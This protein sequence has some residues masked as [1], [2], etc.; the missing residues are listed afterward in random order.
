MDRLGSADVLLFEGFRFDL[1]GSDLLRLDEAGIAVPVV[2]GSRALSLLRLLVERPGKLISR[3]EIMQAVWPR[4]TVEEGNLTV[5][6]SALRRILDQDREQGSCIQT[7]AGRG[8]RFVAPVTPVGRPASPASAALSGNGSNG[9][10]SEKKQ[11]QGPGEPGQIDRTG[12]AAAARA[13]YWLWGGIMTTGIAALVL[14]AAGAVGIWR[15]PWSGDAHTA[16]R[17]SIVVLPFANLGNDPDQQYFADGVTEDLTLD[18]SRIEDLFVISRNTAFTYR[19]KQVDTKQIGRE[20]GVRYVLEGS[21]QRSSNQLRITAQLIDAA[22]DAHLWAERFDRETG[23]LFAL[24]NEIT[25]RIA[26]ALGVELI[27][28][29]AARPNDHPDALDYIL[30]GRAAG[31]KGPARGNTAQ[32]ISLFESALALDP[33]SVE[34][35]S[36][37]AA[38]LIVR[39]IIGATDSAAADTARAD[40][41]IGQTLAASPRNW[42][43]HW[44]KGQV[45][46]AQRRCEDAIPEYEATLAL[47]RNFVAALSSLSWCKLYA[48]SIEE[49][50]PLQE[51]AIRLSPRDPAIGFFYGA[52]GFVHLLQS[53]TDEAI[54]W[55]E[56]ARSALPGVP[57]AYLAAAYALKGETERA[58]A[59][60]AEARRLSGD[61]RYSS[62]TRAKAYGP[63]AGYWGV[64][65][66]RALVETTYFAGLRKA[67]M[68]EE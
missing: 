41:L 53:H 26:S 55:L 31:A 10:I 48:G 66:V 30:Q 19:D 49:V 43:A 27:A 38:V 42:F 2:I 64:P 63:I 12:P 37:L 1:S 15:L 6:I 21:V 58:A 44:V 9:P 7:V 40:G 4:I 54:L 22:T 51:Q 24:Q 52:I 39:V 17:L 8:Y 3:D 29:E 60:L 57:H 13:R 18:L 20:L 35:Q 28:R 33:Q 50:I 36:R 47:N 46:R 14:V 67:G 32:A 23:D 45:L 68:P 16:P 56:K 34:A 62:I 59:E 25:S 61:G 65:K 5:Q 11:A